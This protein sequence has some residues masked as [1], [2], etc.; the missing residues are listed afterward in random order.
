MYNISSIS[1]V[2]VHYFAL[3]C[4]ISFYGALFRPISLYFGLFRTI[5][6]KFG[7]TEGSPR[8]T[9]NNTKEYHIAYAK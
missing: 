3:W 2:L 4:A 7:T 5:S 1:N 9:Y 6:A 8:N